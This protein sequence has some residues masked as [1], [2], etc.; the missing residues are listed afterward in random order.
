MT[1]GISPVDS[2]PAVEGEFPSNLVE[3]QSD[4]TGFGLSIDKINFSTGVRATQGAGENASRVSVEVLDETV[5]YT[6]AGASAVTTTVRAKLREIQSRADVGA[7]T[8]NPRL[9]VGVAATSTNVLVMRAQTDVDTGIGSVLQ[10]QHLI[11]TDESASQANPKALRAYTRIGSST[12]ALVTAT[13]AWN[14]WAVSGELDNYSDSTNTGA[15]ATSGVSNKFGRGAVWAGH[16][17]SK[18]WTDNSTDPTQVTDLLGVE[19][20]LSVVGADHPTDSNGLGNRF[21]FDIIAKSNMAAAGWAVGKE[22]EVG[23]GIRIR[24]E[25]VANG[26]YFRYGIVLEEH[27]NNTG[28]IN[29]GI[30]LRNTGAYGLRSTG[31]KTTADISLE[32][33]SQNGILLQ[34]T[35]TG[36]AIRINNGERIALEATNTIK[37]GW[38]SASTSIQFLNGANN[39]VAADLSATPGIRVNGTKVIGARATGWAAMTGSANTTTVYDTSTVTLAQLAGR[40]M[41]IQAAMTTHGLIGT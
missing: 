26:G 16:F 34:G 5:P 4:G 12:N 28:K 23:C 27:A 7:S 21:I 40:V 22:G 9:G 33:D 13:A 32:G 10:V 39:R 31:V 25:A 29:T 18:E 41:S 14:P 20:N 38:D 11:E 35:Y 36:A 30:F 37:F 15:T 19:A 2:I 17:Q 8:P 24:T 6:P 3:F 1:F